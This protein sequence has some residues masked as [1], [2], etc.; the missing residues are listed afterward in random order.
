[1]SLKI[2]RQGS[3]LKELEPFFAGSFGFASSR[4][5]QG[6]KANISRY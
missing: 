5:Y 6:W 1:M 2:G 4:K 3:V